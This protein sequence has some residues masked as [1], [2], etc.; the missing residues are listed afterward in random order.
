MRLRRDEPNLPRPY[1]VRSPK[2]VGYG[3][4]VVTLAF[5]LLY[6]PFSPSALLWPYEWGIV[7]AWIGL[8]VVARLYGKYVQAPLDLA[9]QERIILGEYARSSSKG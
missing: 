2:L 3:A 4:I 1:K 9:E 8:G 6:L 5:I 7:L